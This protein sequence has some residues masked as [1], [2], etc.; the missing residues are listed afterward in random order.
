VSWRCRLF[1]HKVSKS[2][3]FFLTERSQKCERCGARVDVKSK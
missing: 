3:R 2:R 1:G